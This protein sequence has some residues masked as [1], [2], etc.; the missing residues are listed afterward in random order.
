MHIL[1]KATLAAT[2]LAA[3]VL[4]GAPAFAG[5]D[6]DYY[7][8]PTRDSI[9]DDDNFVLPAAKRESLD[10]F[11]TQSIKKSDEGAMPMTGEERPA[12]GDYYQGPEDPK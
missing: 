2:L 1:S 12:D 7:S 5:S 4:G 8:G 10:L 3:G 6:G 11:S 9:M